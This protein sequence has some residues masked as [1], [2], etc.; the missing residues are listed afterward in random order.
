MGLLKDENGK[1]SLTRVVTMTFVAAFFYALVY[2]ATMPEYIITSITSIV[3]V[4]LG[5]M[6][7]R[8]ALLNVKKGQ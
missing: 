7:A 3:L 8:T 4:G 6:S 2:H 1:L 5:G